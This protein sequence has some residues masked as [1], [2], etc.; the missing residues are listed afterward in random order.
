MTVPNDKDKRL[1]STFA[2]KMQRGMLDNDLHDCLFRIP[3]IDSSFSC[4]MKDMSAFF[5]R[6]ESA[7]VKA[8][9]RPCEPVAA[10]NEV[11]EAFSETLRRDSKSCPDCFDRIIAQ[12]SSSCTVKRAHN[13]QMGLLLH[14][15]S[16]RANTCR[17]QD[18]RDIF[19]RL[20]SA[21]LWA[22]LLE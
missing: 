13:F 21:E 6:S 10:H 12:H 18:R 5:S 20:P 11:E 3:S 1:S 15:E 17:K 14:E 9:H 4:C 2:N 22:A 16:V 7:P 19:D 8:F